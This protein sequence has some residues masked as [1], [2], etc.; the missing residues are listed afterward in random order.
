MELQLA[1]T[2]FFEPGLVRYAYCLH[3]EAEAHPTAWLYSPRRLVLRGLAP[4]N[5]EV[6]IRA[7]TAAGQAAANHLRVPLHV[8]A[9]WWQWPLL[10][11]FV[12][13]L[14]IALG[15]AAYWLRLRREQREAAR[16]TEL[17]ANLHDEVG[18]LLTRVSMLAEVLSESH[19]ATEPSHHASRLETRHALDRL[20]YNSRAAVQTM[21]DVVWGIDSRADSMAALLDRMREHLGQTAAAGLRAIF[22]HDGLSEKARVPASVRQH[23]YLV[24]KEAV[25]NTARQRQGPAQHGPPRRGRARHPAHRPS[26]RRSPW[27][28]R[29]PD[30]G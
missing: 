5:Y 28:L 19:P 4:G 7:E 14:L 24:F 6:E 11:A 23:L 20:L 13:G 16:R 25:T 27:L 30:A 3:H 22:T 18:A 15:Y 29:A 12:A 1:L 9:R 26:P 8:E 21:R 17:A 2:E 10:W